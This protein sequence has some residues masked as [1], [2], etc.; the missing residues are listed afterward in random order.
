MCSG[1][2][3]HETPGCLYYGSIKVIHFQNSRFLMFSLQLFV[4]SNTAPIFSTETGLFS[5]QKVEFYLTKEEIVSY[6]SDSATA[7]LNKKL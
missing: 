6:V 2:G 5:L 4:V 7:S 3:G 1:K